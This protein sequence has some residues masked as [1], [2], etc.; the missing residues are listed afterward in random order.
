MTPSIGPSPHRTP[1]DPVTPLEPLRS[2]PLDPLA[3][4]A[5]RVCVELHIHNVIDGTTRDEPSFEKIKGIA[6]AKLRTD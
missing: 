5:A 1:L 3:C 4:A 2:D 6:D